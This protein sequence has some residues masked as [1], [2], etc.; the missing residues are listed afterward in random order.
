MRDSRHD[1]QTDLPAGG[2]SALARSV[3]ARLA[4]REG[5]APDPVD[6]ALVRRLAQVM[7]AGDPAQVG[8]TLREVRR[9]RVTDQ[10]LV[11]QY[12]P[13]A[14]RLLGCAWADDTAPFS[15]VTLGVARMQALVRQFGRD[16]TRDLTGDWTGD[17]TGDAAPRGA[18]RTV[19]LI[20]PEGEQHSLGAIVL[21]SQLRRQGI[22]VRLEIGTPAAALGSLV[23]QK[24]FDSAMVSIACEEQ[25]D[26]CR[27]LVDALRAQSGGRLHVAVGGAVLER[28]VDVRL[29]TGAD[30]ATSDPARAL[31]AAA[32]RLEPAS[33]GC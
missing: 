20:L 28:P 9:A 5:L 22:S 29:R 26:P 3:V 15:D 31:A 2:A 7:V 4:T 1:G 25:L 21:C 8:A 13:A 17:W 18:G 14:A 12:L 11:D 32:R 10:G 19:L 23:A 16:W 27:R 24:H 6:P 33:A 30:I